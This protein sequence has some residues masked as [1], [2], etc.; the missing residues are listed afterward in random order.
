MNTLKRILFCLPVM[1]TVFQMIA[2][3]IAMSL[4]INILPT[5]F[6]S[7]CREHNRKYWL[8]F[9]YFEWAKP[10]YWYE[11]HSTTLGYVNG[12]RMVH[13]LDSYFGNNRSFHIIINSNSDM[14]VATK[15]EIYYRRFYIF[16][17]M[18]CLYLDV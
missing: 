13:F 7:F 11:W 10:I 1:L 4:T 2:T 15:M 5:D 6:E 17:Y 8:L 12:L 9:Q 18:D 3:A 14:W 16:Y